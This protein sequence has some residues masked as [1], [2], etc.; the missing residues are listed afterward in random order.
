MTQTPEDLLDPTIL[1][2]HDTPA[3]AASTSAPPTAG[4]TAC[5]ETRPVDVDAD[6][7]HRPREDR[8]LRLA[9]PFDSLYRNERG[10]LKSLSMSSGL[11]ALAYLPEHHK[12]VN[13]QMDE[14][15]DFFVDMPANPL[16]P[17][18]LSRPPSPRLSPVIDES[19]W[20]MVS[21]AI[22]LQT[23][24]TAMSQVAC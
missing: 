21:N 2:E 16:L 14:L 23:V 6:W 11:G 19:T 7:P 4:V 22:G 10:L 18:D 12:L 3:A 8:L 13:T 20:D 9:F 17:P 1:G 5:A 15:L 24:R